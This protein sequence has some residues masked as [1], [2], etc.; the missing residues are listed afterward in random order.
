[1]KRSTRE[2]QKKVEKLTKVFKKLQITSTEEKVSLY[3]NLLE[4]LNI[5]TPTKHQTGEFLEVP[6]PI[7]ATL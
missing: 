4:R 5:T 1:M 2:H 3:C 7:H 6:K